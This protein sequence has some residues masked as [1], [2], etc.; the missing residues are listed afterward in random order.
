[1][2][3]D[4]QDA[5]APWSRAIGQALKPCRFSAAMLAFGIAV[6]FL[7]N[8][9]PEALITLSQRGNPWAILAFVGAVVVCT[10]AGTSP[11]CRRTSRIPAGRR[12]R[13]A[14]SACTTGSWNGRLGFSASRPWE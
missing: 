13:M 10:R 1:M 7:I 6:F 12:W 9:T 11:A 8:Q 3:M 2:T 4:V 5:I 14:R